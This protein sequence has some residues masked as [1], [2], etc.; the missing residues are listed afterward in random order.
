MKKR[1][2]KLLFVFLFMFAINVK[3]DYLGVGVTTDYTTVN[4]G[5][6]INLSL[7]TDFIWD[8]AL[9]MSN[10]DE[11]DDKYEYVKT[12]E[13][14]YIAE[15]IFI[16]VDSDVFEIDI[17]N[18]KVPN[19]NY[20][21]A[22]YKKSEEGDKTVYEFDLELNEIQSQDK[23]GYNGE[24][25]NILVSN[26]ILKVNANAE[27]GTYFIETF[28][29]DDFDKYYNDEDYV[30][31]IL[32]INVIG[33]SQKDKSISTISI[34][35][36]TDGIAKEDIS[37]VDVEKNINTYDMLYFADYIKYANVFCNTKCKVTNVGSDVYIGDDR[38]ELNF[39]IT[40]ADGT[41]EKYKVTNLLDK[42]SINTEWL[43]D[44]SK[45]IIIVGNKI[46]NA[47]ELANKVA[48]SVNSYQDGF[49]KIIIN[50]EETNDTDKKL[51]E[52]LNRKFIDLD[53]PYIY[54]VEDN[55]I[56]YEHHGYLT[57]E[58]HS[59]LSNDIIKNKSGITTSNT[60]ISNCDNGKCSIETEENGFNL[61]DN[62]MVIV[63]G[64]SVIIILLIILITLIKKSKN[65][66]VNI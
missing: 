34:S 8:E 19:S 38:K 65:E 54:V 51:L 12:E 11:D 9:A 63:I 16:V 15:P 60:T 14:K 48:A 24:V 52:Y 25:N 61:K 13:G 40:Y 10:Y 66:N 7:G 42:A 28:R 59:N 64:L 32:P 4:K 29:T 1:I 6:K 45:T 21:F 2:I 43:Y 20:S 57:E 30:R 50:Y 27:D 41:T 53:N 37:E 3:A 23:K 39:K 49:N 56:I 62:Y 47:E 35:Y 46:E 5:D 22:D 26:L 17:S 58:E 55:K 44:F 36:S 18:N 33:S 31:D